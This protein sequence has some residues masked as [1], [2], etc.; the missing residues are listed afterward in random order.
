MRL[1]TGILNNNP[2]NVWTIG[3]YE[4]TGLSAAKTGRWGAAFVLASSSHPVP[5]LL[6]VLRPRAGNRCVLI[7]MRRRFGCRNSSR[8][9]CGRSS[10]SSNVPAASGRVSKAAAGFLW[11]E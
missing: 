11:L 2:D 10:G 7:E 9:G 5:A 3:Y 6:S 1:F 4:R 8:G